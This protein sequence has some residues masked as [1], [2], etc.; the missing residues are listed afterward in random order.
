[1]EIGRGTLFWRSDHEERIPRHLAIWEPYIL[2]NEFCTPRANHVNRCVWKDRM[3]KDILVPLR[4][5][6]SNGK[7]TETLF[8]FYLVHG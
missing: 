4:S 1:L 7:G 8:G 3:K 2:S 6:A 5:K